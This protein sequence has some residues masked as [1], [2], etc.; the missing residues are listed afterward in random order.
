MTLGHSVP[1]QTGRRNIVLLVVVMEEKHT[2]GGVFELHYC[3]RPPVLSTNVPAWWLLGLQE[4]STETQ[5]EC[6]WRAG[7][8]STPA[9]ENFQHMSLENVLTAKQFSGWSPFLL[10][11]VHEGK[12]CSH[13][14]RAWLS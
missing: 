8:K 2:K 12:D 14:A 4:L 5:N 10:Q 3:E 11:P 6:S 1:E 7:T 13:Q 9:L